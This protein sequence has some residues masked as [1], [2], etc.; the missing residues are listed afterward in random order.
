MHQSI[1]AAPSTPTPLPGYCGAFS[2]PVSSGG[3]AFANFM[4]LRGRAFDNPEFLIHMQ[5]PIR[6]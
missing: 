1:P 4:L 6:I 5:F 2:H 3:G